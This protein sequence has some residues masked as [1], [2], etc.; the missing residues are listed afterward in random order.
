[1]M[2]GQTEASPRISYHKVEK[3]DLKIKMIPIGKP[4]KGGEIFLKDIDNSLIEKTNVEGELIYKGK[5]IFGGY[6]EAY[7]D[8]NSFEK[9]SELK[10]GDLAVKNKNKIFF[11]TGRKSR[12]VKIYGYRLNLDY[13]EEKINS[14]N[15]TVACVGINERIYIFSKEKNLNVRNIVNIPQNAFKVILLK[16]FPLNNNGKISYSKLIELANQSKVN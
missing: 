12:F 13:I 9:I 11:I 4:I 5:N 10:T 2:Y 14:K 3:K 8:L 15:Y 7:D 1:L 16:N 6:A